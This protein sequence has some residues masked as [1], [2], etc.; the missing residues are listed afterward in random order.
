VI[1]D[2]PPAADNDVGFALTVIPPTA[3]VPTAILSAFAATTETPPEIAEIVAVPDPVPAWNITMARPLASV[4]ASDGRI[5]PRVVV[6]VTR[7]P[8]CGGVPDGSINWAIISV[9]P[10]TGSAEVVA[11]RVMIDPLGARRGT[12]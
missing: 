12:F 2:V 4:S 6:N 8:R 3:A 11:S 7:V 9:E 1:V 5:D 10:F